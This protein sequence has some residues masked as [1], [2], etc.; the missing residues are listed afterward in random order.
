LLAEPK[1]M[2]AVRPPLQPKASFPWRRPGWTIDHARRAVAHLM[3][4]DQC[5]PRSLDDVIRN[6]LEVSRQEAARHEASQRELE[7]AISVS[8]DR[9]TAARSMPNDREAAKIARYES[10]LS[11]QMTQALH[12]LQRLQ[13]ARAGAAVPPPAALDVTI[14]RW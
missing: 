5:G 4:L 1:F 7:V 8:M 14:E 10:H 11:R 13:A 6:V 12:E 9:V 3:T 2:E